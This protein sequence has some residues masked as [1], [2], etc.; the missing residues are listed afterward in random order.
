MISV[1]LSYLMVVFTLGGSMYFML[2]YLN[3]PM[4][5]NKTHSY[6]AL[7]LVSLAGLML[8][9]LLLLKESNF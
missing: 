8:S 6:L 7:S 5:P 2:T 1:F 9:V 3:K 4:S